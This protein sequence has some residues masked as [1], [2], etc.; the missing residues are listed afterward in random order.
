MIILSYLIAGVFA[1]LVAGLLGVGG[2]IVV[3]PVLVMA[4]EAQGFHSDVLV[5]MAVA[6]SL[7][8]IVFTSSSSIWNHHIRGA[9][10]WDL[11]KPLAVGI[12]LGAVLGVLTVVQIDGAWLKKL[13][14]IFAVFVALKMLLSHKTSGS[15]PEPSP[16]ALMKAGTFIGW[17]SSIFGIGGG[18]ISVPYLSRTTLD[19]KK[20][21]GTAAACG[22][23][24]AFVG[25]LTNIWIGQSQANLPEW[26]AGYIYLPALLG[27]VIASVYFA[28]V[29]AKLAH[30][31][32]SE[33]LRSLFAVLLLLVGIRFLVA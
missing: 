19:M 17:V 24:I 21:V 18:T 3:V 20:V 8:T 12:T 27:V 11:F 5:H 13:I 28:R 25:A 22:F 29:G 16:P 7:G 4:F 23:P 31:M 30:R 6:T 1:G 33:R 14:G 9:V 26:S 32:P 15:L 10:R 2:G